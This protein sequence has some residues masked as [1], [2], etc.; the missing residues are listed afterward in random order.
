M[1]IN[2]YPYAPCLRQQGSEHRGQRSPATTHAVAGEPARGTQ[3]KPWGK[4]V[5]NFVISSRRNVGEFTIS[6]GFGGNGRDVQWKAME[7]EQDLDA[8]LKFLR[9]SIIRGPD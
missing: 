6:A 3:G 2:G 9:T 1:T 7:S 5:V 8:F 4:D